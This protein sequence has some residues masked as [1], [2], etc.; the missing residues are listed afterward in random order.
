MVLS[1]VAIAIVA[2]ISYIWMTRGFFSAFLNML[3]VL[4]AGAI[5]FAV[6]EPLA[7]KLLDMSPPSGMMSFLGSSA[8]G[9]SLGLSFAAALALL[10]AGVDAT[11]RANAICNKVVDYVGGGICGAIAGT[12]S[13]GIVVMS[14]GFLRLD[15]EFMGHAPIG[16]NTSADASLERQSKLLFPVDVITAG[17]YSHASGNALSTPT[18]LAKWYPALQDAPSVQRMSWGDGSS[19]N[20]VKPKDFNVIG[21]YMLGGEGVTLKSILTDTWNESVQ[22]VKDIEGNDYPTNSSIYGFV[23]NFS[24]GAK[25]KAGQVVIGPGQVRLV[26]ENADGT[27]HAVAYPI[28]IISRT[29]APN[30]VNYARFR[31]NARDLFI[32]SVGGASDTRMGF[33][34]VVAPGFKPVALYVK[35]ARYEVPD[36]KPAETF[37]SPSERDAAI[38]SGTLVM[39]QVDAPETNRPGTGN[40]NR[41]S[42]DDGVKV[43]NVL[44]RTIQDG[45]QGGKLETNQPYVT[46]GT[47]VLDPDVFKNSQGLDKMLRIDKFNVTKDT[48]I[49]QVDVSINQP[50]SLLSPEAQGADASDT[51]VLVT[52][53]GERFEPVGYWYEDQ[54]KV[55]IRY[56]PGEPIRALSQL[57]DDG[58][59]LTKSRSDQQLT[60]IFRPSFGVTI[61]SFEVGRIKLHEFKRP[62]KLENQQK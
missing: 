29:D 37:A 32:P 48:V 15:T 24:S 52:T 61:K 50:I 59:E 20:T 5:A 36:G 4:V 16:F 39:E 26:S 11:I 42:E 1:L 55:V 47:A 44:P 21:R 22:K 23:V 58:V 57:A 25:E 30:K 56:T 53:E 35:N 49:V 6:W 7:L 18:P 19:R 14:I 33:E 31:F 41:D 45:T 62:I 38:K 46:G 3:C 17:F 40:T 10:R 54:G 8:W 60:L 2:G 51:P 12:I 28:A 27:E 9:L 34:F 13:A 43:T